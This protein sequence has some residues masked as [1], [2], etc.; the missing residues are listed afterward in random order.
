[1]SWTL[2]LR[3]SISYLVAMAEVRRVVAEP[4]ASL[5][6]RVPRPALDIV[7]SR[8][9][10]S[11]YSTCFRATLDAIHHWIPGARRLHIFY[12]GPAALAFDFGR[13]ISKTIH[14]H[15]TVYNYYE[16]DDPKY[17]W[18]LNLMADVDDLD[19]VVSGLR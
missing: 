11:A 10:L 14:P 17:C 12:A 7:T 4:L 13:Q 6:L 9:Q 19:F 2:T 16:R 1:M 5:H 18:G 8:A 3:V 15:T